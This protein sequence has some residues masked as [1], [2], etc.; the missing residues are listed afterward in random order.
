MKTAT[1]IKGFMFA[2]LVAATWI[3]L[4]DPTAK[5]P[6]Q[7]EDRV[8]VTLKVWWVPERRMEPVK[9]Y[10]RLNGAEA[11]NAELNE[12]PWFESFFTARGTVVTVIGIQTMSFDPANL[13]CSAEA[14]GVAQ[15]HMGALA[16][17]NKI[18]CIAHVTA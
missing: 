15:V 14:H 1:K 7:D 4:F 9:I 11:Y 18:S 13:H 2:A 6:R 3:Y 5:H 10:Y 12:S 16:Q 17:G 8:Q